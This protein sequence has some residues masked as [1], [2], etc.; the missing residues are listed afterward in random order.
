MQAI[1][2]IRTHM[3]I[4]II[5]VLI[6]LNGIFSMSEIALVSS[7]KTRLENAAKRGSASA[8]AALELALAPN[9]F[10]STVQIGITL[11][12]LLTG[13]YSGENITND[14]DAWLMQFEFIKPY[15]HSVAVVIILVIITFFTLVLGELVPKRIGM[16]SPETIAKLVARPMKIISLIMAPFVW[17][18]TST[19]DLILKI[20]RVKPSDDSKV[21]EEEIK[22]IV[23]EGAEGGEVQEIE[24]NIV[25]RVFNLGD[26]KVGSLMTHRRDVIFI[27]VNMG[28]SEVRN[29]VLKEIHSIYPVYENDKDHIIGVVNMKELFV[30]ITDENF[31]LR[32]II[33]RP[34]YISE[35][36]SVYMALEQF[37]KTKYR[38]SIVA[39]EHGMAQGI[40]TINDILEALVGDV[41][42]FY[43]DEFQ[44]T[45][46]EDGSWLIDGHYPFHDFLSY[47][48]LTDIIDGEDFNT[49]SGLILSLMGH[50]PKQGD[51][52]H[53]QNLQFE[54]IDM[55]GVKID[56]VMISRSAAE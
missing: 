34:Y 8:K 2:F 19:T 38:Y 6:L 42:E 32:K 20:L 21:T 3:E 13:I 14:L 12:G 27:D 51:K 41:S 17:L 47:F 31:S 11:V 4:A 28:M 35:N 54:I 46:R 48:D 25:E 16:N 24:Q 10:L 37:K 9:K 36:T 26:R 45:E 39:D 23:Q 30:H 44:I 29:T 15:T 43:S 18:L 55:D 33:H 1:L 40:I 22:A 52:T 50:I 56:K 7:R 49:V 5:L 53:W